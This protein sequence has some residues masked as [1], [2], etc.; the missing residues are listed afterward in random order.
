M[1]SAF[2]HVVGKGLCLCLFGLIR[3]RRDKWCPLYR[4]FTSAMI[5]RMFYLEN[6]SSLNLTQLPWAQTISLKQNKVEAEAAELVMPQ[7]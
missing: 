6:L 4:V 2:L 5:S 3:E 1:L 7:N